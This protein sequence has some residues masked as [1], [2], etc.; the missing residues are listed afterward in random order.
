MEVV[1]IIALLVLALMLLVIFR[2]S[3]GVDSDEVIE[4]MSPVFLDDSPEEERP[5]I[6]DEPEGTEQKNT[7]GADG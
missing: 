4:E 5:A 7:R 3:R 1:I 2:R 6:R